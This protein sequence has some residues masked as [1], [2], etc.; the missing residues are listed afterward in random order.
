ML[1]GIW[2]STDNRK[3]VFRECPERPRW[4]WDVATRAL[5][6]GPLLPRLRG[7]RS[8]LQAQDSITLNA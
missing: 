4:E 6:S 7:Q 2:L 1:E 3:R 8:L 5:A